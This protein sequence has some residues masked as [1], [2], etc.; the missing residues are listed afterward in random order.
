[1][2]IDFFIL[3]AW[4]KKIPSLEPYLKRVGFEDKGQGFPKKLFY[5]SKSIAVAVAID[6]RKNSGFEFEL[7][8]GQKK[9]FSKFLLGFWFFMS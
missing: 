5:C 9:I 4:Y 1:L 8:K 2:K 3:S 6:L 7:K